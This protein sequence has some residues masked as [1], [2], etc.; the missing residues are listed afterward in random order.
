MFCHWYPTSLNQA[1]LEQGSLI[2]KGGNQ[3]REKR[4]RLPASR[5]SGARM[6]WDGMVNRCELLINVVSVGKPKALR[7][8]S[9][10]ASGQV[11][12]LPYFLTQMSPHRRRDST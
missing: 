2:Q 7:G 9:Q 5:W 1:R 12:E 8:L 11:Q 4:L 6:G 3:N 10:K